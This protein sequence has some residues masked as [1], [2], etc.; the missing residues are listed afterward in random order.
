M[1]TLFRHS[2]HCFMCNNSKRGGNVTRCGCT[3]TDTVM[4]VSQLSAF[5][6]YYTVTVTGWCSGWGGVGGVERQPADQ[7]SQRTPVSLRKI[8]TPKS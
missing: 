7:R 2:V 8:S 5:A 6:S 4:A 3:V 1:E